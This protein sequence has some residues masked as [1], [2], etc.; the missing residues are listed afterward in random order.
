VAQLA[1]CELVDHVLYDGV[2]ITDEWQGNTKTTFQKKSM[3]SL[4]MKTLFLPYKVKMY[5]K[6]I[7]KM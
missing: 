2:P 5:I 1:S 6:I 4:N 7:V 3:L